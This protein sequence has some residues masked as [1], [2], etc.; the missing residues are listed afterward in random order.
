M[1][2]SLPALNDHAEDRVRPAAALVHVGA[3][4]VAVFLTLDQNAHD[5]FRTEDNFLGQSAHKNITL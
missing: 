1:L 2:G 4:D 3:P 5:L